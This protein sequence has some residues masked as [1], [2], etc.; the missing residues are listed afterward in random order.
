VNKVDHPVHK[1]KSKAKVLLT[2][3]FGPYAQNDEYGSRDINPMELYQNQVTRTQGAFSLRMFHRSFGLMLIQSNLDAP[4][5]L[6]DFPSLHTFIDE[7]KYKTYDIIGISAITPNVGKVKE[8][9]KLIRQHQPHATIVIG[10]HI[11]NMANLANLIDAD[12]IVCG[13]GVRWFRTYLGQDPDAPVKHPESYSGF[14]TRI[15]GLGLKEKPGETA[16]ILL[17]SVGCPL[18]CNFCSTSALFGGKGKSIHFYETGDELFEVMCQLEKNLKVSSFFALDENFLFYRKRALRLLELMEEHSKS[19]ALYV[20]SSAKVLRSYSMEQLIGL[21]VSWVWMGLEGKNSQYA[22]LEDINTRELVKDLQDNGIRVLGSSIIGMEDH[23]PENISEVIDDAVSHG[24]VFH[25]FMLYTP[26]HGTPLYKELLEKGTLLTEEEFPVADSHGQYKFNYRHSHIR[27]GQEEQFL[28]NAFNR[29]FE[30]NGPSLTR[31]FK[32]TLNGLIKYKNHPSKRISDRYKWE[33]RNLGLAYAGATW[34]IRRYFRNDMKLR[35][36]LDSLL[37]D[38]YR[39][40]GWKTRV[41]APLMGMY[42]SRMIRKE[43]ERLKTGWT[44]EP[45]TFYEKNPAAQMLEKH[46]QTSDK[47][48]TAVSKKTDSRNCSSGL[49]V[50]HS[51]MTD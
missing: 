49:K 3:V 47:N 39:E 8:M 24:T 7:I 11:A 36:D 25:Q 6:L 46:K 45:P 22:K 12:H 43:E 18:G 16:A 37:K 10:G 35:K 28:L 5:T 48:I 27:D 51:R 38:I 17:P 19:W 9:C 21:G 33:A 44:Y 34:A 29:D 15:L 1:L 42:I 32:T 2:S 4:T 31:M 23:T 13:E 26:T 50:I 40:F 30:V 20:F 14:N 41:L